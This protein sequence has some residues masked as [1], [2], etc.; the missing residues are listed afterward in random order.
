MPVNDLLLKA[1]RRESVSRPPVWMMRQA[2]RYLPQYRAIRATSDF[3]TMCRTPEMAAEVTLQ[4]VDLVGVDAA[5]IFSDILVIPEAMGCKLVLDEGIGPQF[6]NPLRSLSAIKGLRRIDA[7]ADL[8]YALEAIRIVNRELDE[9]V[10][11]IGFAGAPWT[12]ASYM[13]EGKGTKQFAIAKKMLFENPSAAHEL[14]ERLTEAVIDFA[15]AQVQA[16]AHVIQLFDSWAGAL[17][18]EEFRTFSLPYLAKAT[19][20]IRKAGAPVIVFANGASSFL[21]EIADA[22]QADAVGIDWHITP[23]NAK[24]LLGDRK[25]AM[26][27]NLDPCVL[28]SPIQTIEKRTHQMLDAFGKTGYIA[29]LGHGIL[30]DVSPDHARAFIRAVKEHEWDTKNF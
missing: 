24:S 12:L 15:T 6:P 5:I 22:T 7:H 28:Y 30:P 9:R 16:G 4:P 18:P 20:E 29:N 17:G 11:L 27:G 21:A 19:T 1:L 26:Q 13:V 2:G 23:G 14:L 3:L 8:A 25:V 10:P